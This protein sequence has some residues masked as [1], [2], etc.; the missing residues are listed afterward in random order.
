MCEQA[1]YQQQFCWV[2]ALDSPPQTLPPRPF[3]SR[4]T[5]DTLLDSTPAKPET[6]VSQIAISLLICS[7]K[8]ISIAHTTRQGEVVT[9]AFVR[10]ETPSQLPFG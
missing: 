9:V 8:Q 5:S 2:T 7:K 6:S 1:S 4:F 10:H 3:H